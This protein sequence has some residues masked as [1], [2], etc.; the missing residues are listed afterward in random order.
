MESVRRRGAKPPLCRT[1]STR[2]TSA[3]AG[4]NRDSPSRVP[5]HRGGEPP[6]STTTGVCTILPREVN[7]GVSNHFR[8]SRT[9]GLSYCPGRLATWVRI[10]FRLP[11]SSRKCCGPSDLGSLRGW[12]SSVARGWYGA[13]PSALRMGQGAV[14]ERCPRLVWSG[15]LVLKHKATGSSDWG[16]MK[17]AAARISSGRTISGR[18]HPDPFRSRPRCLPVCIGGAP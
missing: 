12:S 14:L 11:V 8:V 2:R 6:Q 10:G 7:R 15:P 16:I 17:P 4:W 18:I 13:G 1:S 3:V 5:L 9:E